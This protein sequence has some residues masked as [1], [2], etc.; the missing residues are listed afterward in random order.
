MVQNAEDS[1][2]EALTK[3]RNVYNENL[4]IRDEVWMQQLGGAID[5]LE[6]SLESLTE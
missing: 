5:I 3:C 1:I 4:D 2:K 6:K